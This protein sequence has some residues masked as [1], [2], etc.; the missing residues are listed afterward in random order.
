M[1]VDRPWRWTC[2]ACKLAVYRHDPGLPRGWIYTPRTIARPQT[3]HYCPECVEVVPL[4]ERRYP[5]VVA[6]K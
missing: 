1:P 2:T 5:Q 6:E 3:G 4:A